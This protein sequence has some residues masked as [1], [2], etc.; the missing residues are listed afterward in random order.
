MVVRQRL[1]RVAGE[2]AVTE[3]DGRRAL[4]SHDGIRRKVFEVVAKLARVVFLHAN[5]G[6]GTINDHLAIGRNPWLS[7]DLNRVCQRVH[8]LELYTTLTG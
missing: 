2:R 8:R 7:N 1:V 3:H 6:D 4:K 5:T